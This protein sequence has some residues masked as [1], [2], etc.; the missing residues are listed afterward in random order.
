MLVTHT[1][2][3]KKVMASTTPGYANAARIQQLCRR[4]LKSLATPQ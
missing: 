4:A 3:Y 1:M 2:S